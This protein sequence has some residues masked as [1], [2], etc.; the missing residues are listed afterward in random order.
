MESD[1]PQIKS[2]PLLVDGVL[3]FTV[4]D[5]VWAVNAH[6][7]K[8]IWHYQWNDVGGHLVGNRGVGIYGN[9]L[10]FLS[11]DGWFI[12]LNAKDGK[13]RWRQ[14]IADQKASVLHYYGRHGSG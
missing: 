2:T 3:Y 12:S 11:P 10:Y 9:W 8:S 7:G 6:T 13:E 14:H 4:P 5:H 1:H